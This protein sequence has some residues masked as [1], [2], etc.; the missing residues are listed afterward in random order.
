VPLLADR[1]KAEGRVVATGGGIVLNADN[2]ILMKKSGSIIWL[3]VGLVTIKA[4]MRQ[5]KDSPDFRPALTH[6][7]SISEIEET[8]HSR[9]AIYK[10]AMDFFVDTD[11]YDVRVVTD[12]IIEKLKGISPELFGAHK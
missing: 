5:D 8:L 2:V 4:R 1:R 6:N 12:I 11:E 7:D 10:D 9:E 3:K